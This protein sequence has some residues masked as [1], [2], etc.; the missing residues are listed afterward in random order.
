MKKVNLLIL[1]VL[2][3]L[4]FVACKGKVENDPLKMSEAAIE[5]IN[6]GDFKSLQ[7]LTKDGLNVSFNWMQEVYDNPETHER[8]YKNVKDLVDGEYTFYLNDLDEDEAMIKYRYVRKSS[9]VKDSIKMR[10]ERENGTWYLV[11]IM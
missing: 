4:G 7:Q 10:F 1:C 3:T 11:Y 9:K 2:M 6:K 5:Y 8:E